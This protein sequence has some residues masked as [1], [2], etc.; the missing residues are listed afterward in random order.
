MVA[1]SSLLFGTHYVTDVLA[2]IALGLA[3]AGVV[4]TLVERIFQEGTEGNQEPAQTVIDLQG[5]RAPGL[6]KKQPSSG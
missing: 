5:L 2:G 1:L 4:Y 3:W 6:F